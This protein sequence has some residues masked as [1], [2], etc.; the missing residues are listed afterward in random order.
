VRQ[1]AEEAAE[2]EYNEETLGAAVRMRPISN[3]HNAEVGKH[4]QVV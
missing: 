1:R 2:G 3:P 4:E